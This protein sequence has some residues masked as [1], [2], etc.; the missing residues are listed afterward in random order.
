MLRRIGLIAVIFALT[1]ATVLNWSVPQTTYSASARGGSVVASRASVSGNRIS[2]R[3][4]PAPQLSAGQ[5]EAMRLRLLEI[6]ERINAGVDNNPPSAP[7]LAGPNTPPVPPPQ[8]ARRASPGQ[9][10]GDLIQYRNV[11]DPQANVPP[12]W[13]PAEPVAAVNG[14]HILAAGN[15]HAEVS[16]N[17]GATWTDF[18]FPAGP[19]SAPNP[20][21]DP[22]TAFDNGRRVTFFLQLYSNNAVTHGLVRIFVFNNIRDAIQGSWCYYDFEPA[23]DIFP[24]YPKLTL[25]SDNLVL[26]TNNIQNASTWP[27]S[28]VYRFPIE[29]MTTCAGF[30]YNFINLNAGNGQRVYFPTQGT[31]PIHSLYWHEF[32]DTSTVRIYRWR[33]L[34][35]A[36]I[37]WADRSITTSAFGAP[38]A[39]CN[40][41]TNGL[42]FLRSINTSIAGFNSVSAYGRGRIYLSW[43]AGPDATRTA[44]HIRN[45]IFREEPEPE[46]APFNPT[47]ILEW[48]IYTPNFCWGFPNITS[49]ERGDFGW[50]FAFGGNGTAVGGVVTLSD[51]DSDPGRGLLWSASQYSIG[52]G[53]YNPPSSRYGD[54]LGIQTGQPCSKFYSGMN[55][56]YSGG[57]AQANIVMRFIEFGRSRDYWCWGNWAMRRPIIRP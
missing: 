55:Y 7:G 3:A 5:R 51:N 12:Y 16:L 37:F 24:D 13:I 41:G 4:A 49:N 32:L 56:A 29:P 2:G 54:Y 27:N 34:D 28:T 52:P 46:A 14:S 40:G 10:P 44:A 11:S 39:A 42:S 53:T 31:G 6:R 35:G 50:N 23:S 57:T 33:D 30:S 25:N 47:L 1:T 20:L 17:G 43:Q 15:V 26:T 18:P 21:G 36:T 48:F 19:V 38:T 8:P 22:F 9:V 45:A